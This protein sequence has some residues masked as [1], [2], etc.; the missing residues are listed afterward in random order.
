MLTRRNLMKYGIGGAS[1][2]S[3]PG[4]AQFAIDAPPAKHC[5]VLW[6]NGV[7]SHV[8]TFDP[9]P[10]TTSAGPFRAINTSA[11]NVQISEHLPLLA[12]LAQSHGADF[13]G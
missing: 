8:D 3:R 9:K 2:R 6:M 1:V 12:E 10:N 13:A 5:I 7:P 4:S 11:E